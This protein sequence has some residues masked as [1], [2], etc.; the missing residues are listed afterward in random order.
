MTKPTGRTLIRLGTP[1]CQAIELL[2]PRV[3]LAAMPGLGSGL[4]ANYYAEENLAQLARAEVDPVVD[5]NWGSASP[6]PSVPADHFS[7]RWTGRLQ[8]QFTETYTFH[9]RSDGGVRLHVNGQLILDAWAEAAVAERTGTIALRAGDT[10]DFRLEYRDVTG[11]AEVRLSWS[12]PS[13]PKAVIP[14]NQLYPSAGW[15]DSDL[16]TAAAP[17][18]AAST[19][20]TDFTLTAQGSASSHFLYQTFTQDGTLTARIDSPGTTPE[21][22]AGLMLRHSLAANSPFA[23]ISFSQDGTARLQYRSTVGAVVQTIVSDLLM[24]FPAYARLVRNGPLISAYA[25]PIGDDDSWTLIGT[26]ALPAEASKDTAYLGLAASS[27]SEAAASTASFGE[28]ALKPTLQLGAGLKDIWEIAYANVFVDMVKQARAFSPINNRNGLVAVD[29][30]GWPTSDFEVTLQRSIPNSGHVY[31]GTYKMSFTG[32][33]TVQPSPDT[34]ATVLNKVYDPG[35]NT[36]TADVVLNGPDSTDPNEPF[37]WFTLRFSS[38][39]RGGGAGAGVTNLRVIRPGYDPVNAPTFTTPILDQLRMF[40]TVR[41]MDWTYTNGSQQVN[42]S[43]RPKL[44][45]ARQSRPADGKSGFAWGK[46]AA[47]EYLVDFVN[48]IDKDLWINVPHLATNDY[49]TQLATL[50][51]DRLEPDR[52]VYIEYSNEVWNYAFPQASYNNSQA[53]AEVAAGGSNLNYDGSSNAN[54]LRFRRYARRA[55][56]IGQIFAGVFGAG[57][58]NTRVRPV[59]AGQFANP[60]SIYQ[61][62]EY[63]NDNYG[64]PKDYLYAVAG[65][66]YF[67]ME[68][69]QAAAD[70][71]AEVL[72]MLNQGIDDARVRFAGFHTQ[73]GDYGL[74]SITY[75]GGPDTYGPLNVTAKREANL[76]PAMKEMVERYLTGWWNSGGELFSWYVAG[77]TSYYCTCGAW[78]LT[79]DMTNQNTPKLQA[80]RELLDSPPPALTDGFNAP[81]TFNARDFYTPPEYPYAN[82]VITAPE[83]GAMFGYLI[84]APAD[85]TYYLSLNMGAQAHGTQIEVAV[86][87]ASQLVNVPYTGGLTMYADLA[88]ISIYLSAGLN[89]LRLTSKAD[90]QYNIKAVTIATNNVTSAASTW[91]STAA[92]GNWVDAANWINGVPNSSTAYANFDDELTVRRT[93]SLAAPTTLSALRFDNVAGY[94]LNAT[95]GGSLTLTSASGPA[96]LIV[97]SGSPTINIPLTLAT[98]TDVYVAAGSTLT[99]AGNLSLAAGVTLTKRGPGELVIHSSTAVGTAAAVVAA[100]GT[101][102]FNADTPQLNLSATGTAHL[103]FGA[104]QR[105]RS[106]TLADNSTA[107]FASGGSGLVLVVGAP[108]LS[109]SARLDIGWAKMI[110]RATAG[111]KASVYNTLRDRLA[112]ARNS[113]PNRWAGPG[114]ASA[115]AVADWRLG[116]GLLDNFEN[117]QV[118]FGTFGGESVD[119]N[120][121]LL[122][123]AFA[124]DSDL[125]GQI[126]IDDYFRIDRAYAGG[127][128]NSGYQNGDFNYDGG[129]PDGDDYFLID[130]GFV[131]QGSPLAAAFSTEAIPG[132]M[133]QATMFDR[134]EASDGVD[135]LL[136]SQ[137]AVLA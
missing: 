105:P 31:N 17:G 92:S 119:S 83:S 86:N 15:L 42:W 10:Y 102:R 51:R 8:A 106:L 85:G 18:S 22:W 41:F 73:A 69:D 32:Q 129:A 29:A 121:L 111:T 80:M 87:G 89:S 126:D 113:T 131:A 82:A 38:T 20:S 123:A 91:T 28:V 77:A 79:G 136:E 60:E 75:E 66:P 72:A 104:S 56:E 124:G 44:T 108:V 112:A 52:A 4:V 94:T 49:V 103:S 21:A 101:V 25:S 19:S 58:L 120:S 96:Q 134:D 135:D 3:L 27:G 14:S 54:S 109:S 98:N 118:L 125:S 11:P 93:I 43:D 57:S 30:N 95:G 47:W 132:P 99:I 107:S 13:T 116:V 61:G 50:I 35:T 40:T 7:V 70:T 65:A 36:T 115:A 5:F 74:R 39:N 68:G 84:K 67:Y 128:A 62:L 127:N 45:D 26:A 23:L 9:V 110:V 81:G 64:P 24:F 78:G 37:W 33:A 117:G 114:I 63:L 34:P 53:Q 48:E 55:R 130:L 2:E 137:A 71:K 6:Q 122:Q 16:G 97:A 90:H 133:A 76:D 100:E 59:L 46:G 1:S 88:P 12:S